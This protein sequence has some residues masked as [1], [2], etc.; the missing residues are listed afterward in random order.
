MSVASV[1][2]Q[3]LNPDSLMTPMGGYSQGTVAGDLV[4]VAGQT[5]VAADLSIPEPGDVAAQTRQ[6]I[7]NIQALLETA[8]SSLS[9]VV[10]TT[11]YLK[12]FDDYAEF[13]RVY[14]E[15]FDGHAP[16]RA[17]VRAD[18]VAPQLLVEIQAIA[19][20]GNQEGGPR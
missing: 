3:T 6:T 4:F 15:C 17:T 18:L 14:R 9:L 12:T 19:V 7:A 1:N 2:I 10:S 13:D 11:V 20:R 8:G 16:A 5:G